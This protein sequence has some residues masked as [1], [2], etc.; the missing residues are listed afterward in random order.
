MNTSLRQ[1]QMDDE[2]QMAI[3]REIEEWMA[4]ERKTLEDL[5]RRYTEDDLVFAWGCGY[6]SRKREE[7][8]EVE[9][10]TL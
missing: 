4:R 9:A 5:E 3:Q 10:I 1:K 7:Q 6:E 2:V 8:E